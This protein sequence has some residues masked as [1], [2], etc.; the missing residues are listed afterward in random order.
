MKNKLIQNEAYRYEILMIPK[1]NAKTLDADYWQK[2]EGVVL[3]FD[4]K[5][6]KAHV[7]SA[8]PMQSDLKIKSISL[9]L[10]ESTGPVY[11]L[12]VIDS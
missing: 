11:E 6:A 4:R 3:A 8:Y 12:E 2:A 5:T 9:A 10:V 1:K 7:K